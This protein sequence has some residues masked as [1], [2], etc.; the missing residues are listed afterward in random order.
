MRHMKPVNTRS[1]PA[2]LSRAMR[3]MIVALPV[4]LLLNLV[5]IWSI[6]DGGRRDPASVSSSEIAALCLISSL[7]GIAALALTCSWGRR[8]VRNESQ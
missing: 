2:V 5:F 7:P 1:A 6:A 3:T 4:A 8:S